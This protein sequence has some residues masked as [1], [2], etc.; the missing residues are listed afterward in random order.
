MIMGR[1]VM[2]PTAAFQNALHNKMIG[3]IKETDDTVPYR[4]G[5]YFYYSRTIAGQQYPVLDA[6]LPLTTS[7]YVEWGNPNEKPAYDYMAK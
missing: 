2:K 5:D 3:H 7:E 6:T 4:R 1:A